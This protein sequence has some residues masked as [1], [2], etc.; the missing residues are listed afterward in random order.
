MRKILVVDDSKEVADLITTYLR[1]KGFEVYVAY[2]AEQALRLLEEHD[3]LPDDLFDLMITD[4]NMPGMSGEEFV[5]K[6]RQEFPMVKIMMISSNE[7]ESED[8]LDFFMK[9]PLDLLFL[10]EVVND[11]TID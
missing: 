3:T 6:V 5:V 2:D 9:K 10:Y 1:G 7:P 4:N 11:L 8:Q